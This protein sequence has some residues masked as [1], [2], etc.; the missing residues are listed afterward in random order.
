MSYPGLFWGW[1]QGVTKGP[2]K[3]GINEAM[4][5]VWEFDSPRQAQPGTDSKALI[6]NSEPKHLKRHEIN[7]KEAR[8][9]DRTKQLNCEW[10]KNDQTCDHTSTIYK[11]EPNEHTGE[12]GPRKPKPKARPPP[13][14]EAPGT[15]PAAFVGA[16]GSDGIN[17]AQHS[18]D[19]QSLGI[20]HVP[21]R[22]HCLPCGCVCCVV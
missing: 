1:Q 11:R 9:T 19:K 4:L 13:P 22:L 12:S 21:F 3:A 5:D 2:A 20:S 15:R 10:T 6:S 16:Q 8:L 14:R 17:S 7:S 18:L